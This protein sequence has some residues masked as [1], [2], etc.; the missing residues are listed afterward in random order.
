LLF[1]NKQC[2]NCHAIGGEGGHRGPDLSAVGTRM[3]EAQLVRQVIQGGGNM[4]AYGNNLSQKEV[5]ALVTYLVSLRPA[6]T[7]PAQNPAIQEKTERVSSGEPT[8]EV[9]TGG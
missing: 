8:K 2:R 1:Q 9:Q 6:E 3:G 7:V 5:K 4:P